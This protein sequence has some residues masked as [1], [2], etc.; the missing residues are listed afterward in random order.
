MA[1][2]SIIN[3]GTVDSDSPISSINVTSL[4]DV[5]FC[6]LIMFMVA[7]PLI[8]P[9]GTEVELPNARG[10]AI[11]KDEALYKVISIDAKGNH[12]LGGMALSNDPDKLKAEITGNAK[13]GEDGL[14][15][16]QADKNL[17]H[18]KIVDLLILLKETDVNEVGFVIDP[19]LEKI[20]KARGER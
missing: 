4:V 19:N 11:S 20:K 14:L 8:S 17:D 10:L 16:I 7:T 3:E 12:F 2:H 9:D 1:K 6:L 13:L 15:F 18:A 5:M